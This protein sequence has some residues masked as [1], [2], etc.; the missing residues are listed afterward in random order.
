MHLSYI[1]IS[2]C[3]HCCMFNL[4]DSKIK[5]KK[6]NHKDLLKS[7]FHNKTRCSHAIKS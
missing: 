4:I 2:V 7:K 1:F 3:V 5:S 6:K